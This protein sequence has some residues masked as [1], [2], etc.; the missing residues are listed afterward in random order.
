MLYTDSKE[1]CLKLPL[2]TPDENNCLM[3]SVFYFMIRYSLEYI[4]PKALNIG[5]N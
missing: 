5:R 4:Y 1:N 3:A 2:D